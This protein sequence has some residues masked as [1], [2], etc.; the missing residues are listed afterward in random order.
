LTRLGLEAPACIALEIEEVQT[1]TTP[2]VRVGGSFRSVGIG[3]L[4][5]FIESV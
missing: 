2:G 4:S 3:M 5:P 1:F